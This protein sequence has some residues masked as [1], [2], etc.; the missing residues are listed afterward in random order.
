MI[1]IQPNKDGN[2]MIFHDA[3]TYK[4]EDFIE[5]L[6]ENKVK[7]EPIGF[8]VNK[9]RYEDCRNIAKTIESLFYKRLR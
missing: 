1:E 8:G 2:Y 7:R 3:K 9:E 4:V 6:E 5:Y